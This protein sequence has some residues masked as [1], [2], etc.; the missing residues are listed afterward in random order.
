MS[1]SAS[2][3][4]IGEIFGE[5]VE[6]APAERLQRLAEIQLQDTMLAQELA[7]LLVAHDSAENLF[8]EKIPSLLAA[9]LPDVSLRPGDRVLHFEIVE[10]LGEGSM[11]KVY[12]ARDTELERQVALKVTL[13]QSK[14][15]KTLAHFN[16]DGIIQVYSEHQVE[17]E[18]VPLRLICLQLVSGPT[19]ATLVQKMRAQAGLSI[20]EMIEQS[21]P[22]NV[23]FE[24]SALKWREL[25]ASL[26]LPESL[27]MMGMRL[28]EILSHA[29]DVGVLHLDIK[30]ANVLIDPY[31]RPFLSDFNV[32]TLNE[33][34]LAGDIRGLGG[35]PH[36]MPPEQ[37][38]FFEVDSTAQAT[39]LSAK[40]DV[41]AL[42]VVIRDLMQ[43]VGFQNSDLEKILDRAT[44]PA[45]SQRTS[46]AQIFAQELRAWL[47]RSLAEKEMPRVWQGFGWILKYPLAA[48]IILNLAVQLVPGVVNFLY[49]QLQTVAAL[50]EEQNRVFMHAV[51]I[52]NPIS[53]G[54]S[55]IVALIL[56]RPLVQKNTT[57]EQARRTVLRIPWLLTFII[58]SAW[59]VGAAVFPK[60][61]DSYA[62]PIPLHVYLQFAGSFSLSWL[63]SL[64]TSLAVT[65]F[66][67]VR[68]LYPRYWNGENDLAVR[69]LK[70]SQNLSR[71][72]MF[73]S[74]FVPMCGAVIVLL[75][76]PPDFTAS[77]YQS[78]KILL[79]VTVGFG[80]LNL[81]FVQRLTRVVEIAFKALQRPRPFD[82]PLF[83]Q[84]K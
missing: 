63:M 20:L 82:Q 5:L 37:A 17:R 53:Y 49:N 13:N 60:A 1:A 73:A 10:L 58:S 25:L 34:L 24:P 7:S 62:G 46:S 51:S 52:Y 57:M 27:I 61:I 59:L 18:G 14:E 81:L 76:S 79:L 28:A 43:V 42:G 4:Q 64:T 38:R 19:L 35:T 26:T 50:T 39:D 55:I 70:V 16:F 3:A 71:S 6:K 80:I 30:P 74:A 75:L 22:R 56:M 41:Y 83:L 65:I 40:S 45:S 78:L 47:R 72:L 9:A 69:E 48:V 77:H 23:A 8:D 15:A 84:K 44:A 11:A 32:S 54:L 2:W 31:G 67:I 29:H 66:I 36:Y 68:T 21:T 33:R 12:L